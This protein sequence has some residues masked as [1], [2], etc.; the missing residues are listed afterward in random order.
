MAAAFFF[1]SL[2]R[3]HR[4]SAAQPSPPFPPTRS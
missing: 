3:W 2:C 4:G 1:L